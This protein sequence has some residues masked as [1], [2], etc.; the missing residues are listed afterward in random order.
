MMK[1]ILFQHVCLIAVCG[2]AVA[3]SPVTASAAILQV[4]EVTSPKGIRA[5]LVE[6]HTVPMR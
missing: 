1:H 6:D 4:Q 5:W 3:F 2:I